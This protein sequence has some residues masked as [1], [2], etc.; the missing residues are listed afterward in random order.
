MFIALT[1]ETVLL[2]TIVLITTVCFIKVVVVVDDVI[3][4]DLIALFNKV[5]VDVLVIATDLAIALTML[6]VDATATDNVFTT[7]RIRVAVLVETTLN[8]LRIDLT[9]VAVD[10]DV[11]AKAV[12]TTAFNKLTVEV[13]VTTKDFAIDLTTV[14]VEVTAAVIVCRVVVVPSEANGAWARAETPNILE[15]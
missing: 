10:V 9:K 4:A 15:Y 2:V 7:L 6:V 11:I 8:G 3:K 12:L 13:L 14:T 5:T 1:T